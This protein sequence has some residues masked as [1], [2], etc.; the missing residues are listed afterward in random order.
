MCGGYAFAL[1]TFFGFWV[2]AERNNWIGN[3]DIIKHYIASDS[4]IGE[5]KLNRRE[6][7]FGRFGI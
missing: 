7:C 6:I 1:N 2:A 3:A 5:T 4:V